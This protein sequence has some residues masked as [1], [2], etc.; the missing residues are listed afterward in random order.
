MHKPE[1][2]SKDHQMWNNIVI[3]R[4]YMRVAIII[5]GVG[6]LHYGLNIPLNRRTEITHNSLK[7]DLRKRKRQEGKKETGRKESK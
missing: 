4:S 1:C 5:L 2:I 7:K 6:N 3:L